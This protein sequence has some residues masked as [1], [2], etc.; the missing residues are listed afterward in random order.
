MLP[1]YCL[2]AG[3]PHP[4]A[5]LN[6]CCTSKPSPVPP[7][8]RQRFVSAMKAT[9]LVFGEAYASAVVTT[10][11][12]AAAGI[13]GWHSLPPSGEEGQQ[14]QQSAEVCGSEALHLRLASSGLLSVP[15]TPAQRLA[16]LTCALPLL[17]AGVLPYAGVEAV[18]GCLRRLCTDGGSRS[19][20][21]WALEHPRAFVAA[22]RSAAEVQLVQVR[23]GDH[24]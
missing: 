4:A 9:C 22:V 15:A 11:L 20:Q 7:L 18:G 13:P 14:Q 12:Q 21:L 23:R 3:V 6:A 8:C 1:I 5:R 17:L 24:L 2:P 16:G 10:Q 19:G